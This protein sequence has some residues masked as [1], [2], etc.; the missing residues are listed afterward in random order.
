MHEAV[1][2]DSDT[3]DTIKFTAWHL[4]QPLTI[5]TVIKSV[6]HRQYEQSY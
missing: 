5:P 3:V 2:W 6:P 4:P 1:P